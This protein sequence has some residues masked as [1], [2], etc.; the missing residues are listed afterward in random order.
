MNQ[1]SRSGDRVDHA[2]DIRRSRE[3]L[4][5]MK[6]KDEG[7]SCRQFS[8]K[9]GTKIERK[10]SDGTCAQALRL[11]KGPRVWERRRTKGTRSPNKIWGKQRSHCINPPFQ[12]AQCAGAS[13]GRKQALQLGWIVSVSSQ[14]AAERRRSQS[15]GCLVHES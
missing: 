8:G 6:Q 4:H 15:P 5:I 13:P 11:H 2:S 12:A 1:G 3:R 7:P 9:A 14:M 10:A